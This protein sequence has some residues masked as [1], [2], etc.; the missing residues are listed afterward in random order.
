MSGF[1]RLLLGRL[2]LLA[3]ILGADIFLLAVTPHAFSLL[4]PFAPFGIASYAVYLGLGYSELKTQREELPFGIGILPRS[5][6]LRTHDLAGRYC[7]ASWI[8]LPGRIHDGPS[9]SS[10]SSSCWNC[11]AGPGLRSTRDLGWYPSQDQAALALCHTRRRSRV[12]P[13]ASRCN[14]SGIHPALHLAD[15]CRSSPFI[16]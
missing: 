7:R 11:S 3:G 16:L 13:A 10:R 5:P 8:R 4:G 15:S 1:P 6:G 14:P 12:V 9:R 2:F